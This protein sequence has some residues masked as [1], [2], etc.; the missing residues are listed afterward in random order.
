MGTARRDLSQQKKK[1]RGRVNAL[2]IAPRHLIISILVK[3]IT[4]N[5]FAR[6]ILPVDAVCSWKSLI[7]EESKD[8]FEGN[9]HDFDG[10]S[11]TLTNFVAFEEHS[12][13]RN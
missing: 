1:K 13:Q 4:F 3:F 12:R 8:I 11:R 7:Y 6:G 9:K 2:S 10:K 5:T